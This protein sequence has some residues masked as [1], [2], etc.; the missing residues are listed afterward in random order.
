MVIKTYRSSLYILGTNHSL[1][2]SRSFLSPR[3]SNCP[4]PTS[5]PALLNLNWCSWQSSQQAHTPRTW[6]TSTQRHRFRKPNHHQC[7]YGKTRNCHRRWRARGIPTR[8]RTTIMCST[9]RWGTSSTCRRSRVR[10]SRETYSKVSS[11]RCRINLSNKSWQM[12]RK[13]KTS[14]IMMHIHSR[15]RPPSAHWTPPSFFQTNTKKF[16][17]HLLPPK[18]RDTE[19]L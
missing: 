19:G 15:A 16:N 6:Y 10:D 4:P 14:R 18:H 12:K 5:A 1:I 8:R 13:E 3:I 17:H 7:K 9:T 2:P 11:L